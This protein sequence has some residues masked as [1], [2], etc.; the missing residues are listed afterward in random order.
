MKRNHFFSIVL[1]LSI[2]GLSLATNS[3]GQTWN[4]QQKDVWT[5]VDNYWA[6]MAKGDIDG[7]MTYFGADYMGWDYDSPVPQSKAAT[8][9]YMNNGIKNGKTVFYDLS[10]VAILIYGDI[11]IVD[12]Y[13]NTQ[14]ENLEGKK[15]WRSGR[16]TDVLQKL[17]GGSKWVLIADHGGDVKN[18]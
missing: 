2:A 11:A 17:S 3:Y 9:K 4:Q 12:Y 8:A 16:W 15:E 6:L 10:P 7:F 18:K 5:N 1:L 14:R 13:F